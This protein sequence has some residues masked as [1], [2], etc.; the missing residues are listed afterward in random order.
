MWCVLLGVFLAIVWLF[1]E[2][3]GK[4]KP[5]QKLPER[6]PDGKYLH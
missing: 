1:A 4:E 3:R 6:A 2:W 5:K